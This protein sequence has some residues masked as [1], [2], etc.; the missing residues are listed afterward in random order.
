MVHYCSGITT[1]GRQCKRK[2]DRP[3]QYCFQHSNQQ[4][5]QIQQ[6]RLL[7]PDVIARLRRNFSNVSSEESKTNIL[8]DLF[9]TLSNEKSL[10]NIDIET[11]KKDIA[12]RL[13]K[14]ESELRSLSSEIISCELKLKT[15]KG[16]LDCFCNILTFG[17]GLDDID[18]YHKYRNIQDETIFKLTQIL[19]PQKT[20]YETFHFRL[21]QMQNFSWNTI[22]KKYC[23][24][25][26]C[27]ICQENDQENG[28]SLRCHHI[29][30]YEC[31]MNHLIRKYN[32]PNCRF[33][34][35]V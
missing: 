11:I 15:L 32:C 8:D 14:N 9:D 30:H 16:F 28:W 2:L 22:F 1:T 12:E 34:L 24:C 31:I 20:V 3:V 35:F 17:L 33:D 6:Q 27:T 4:R 13:I 7:N 25:F 5:P 21:Q 23:D 26:D 29:F 19:R 18:V 10:S